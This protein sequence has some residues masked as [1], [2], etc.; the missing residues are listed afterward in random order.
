LTCCAM[1][2]SLWKKS[3]QCFATEI[4]QGKSQL[5]YCLLED[6]C[7]THF[8]KSQYK[9]DLLI[10]TSASAFNLRKNARLKN[11]VCTG[12]PWFISQD[13]MSSVRTVLLVTSR[14]SH[15][16]APSVFLQTGCR[17]WNTHGYTQRTFY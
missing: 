15:T 7:E 4:S 1:L 6:T 13:I 11:G 17:I 8:F 12:T 3:K 5:R 14:P 2:I 9:T 16:R 10:F